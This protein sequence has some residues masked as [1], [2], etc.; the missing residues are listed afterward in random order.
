MK[1]EHAQL[2]T[3][4]FGDDELRPPCFYWV[5]ALPPLVSLTSFV[6]IHPPCCTA[7]AWRAELPLRVVEIFLILLYCS[8]N[9]RIL[10][11]LIKPRQGK[12]S[13]LSS[14]ADN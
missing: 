9:A 10:Y 6:T 14:Y 7:I 1:R 3:V 11:K 2:C 8:D 13:G 12:S 5:P 4:A